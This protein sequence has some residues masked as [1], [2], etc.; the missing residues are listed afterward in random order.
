MSTLRL[1]T[2]SRLKT[3]Q[4]QGN[5]RGSGTATRLTTG[6]RPGTRGGGVGATLNTSVH[7]E[8][9]PITQQGLSGLRTADRGTRRQIEDKPY[10]LGLLRSKIN[11]I[12]S[13]IGVLT[14]QIKETEEENASFIQYEQMAEKLALEIKELQGEL[15]DYNTLVDKATL[16][17]DVSNVEMDWE[18]LKSANE[19]ADKSLESLFEEKQ[20]MDMTLKSLEQELKREQQKSESLVQEMGSEERGNYFRL[21]DLNDHLMAQLTEGQAQLD[22]LNARRIELEQ[23]ISTSQAKQEAMRLYAQ[24]HEAEAK[25]DQL[26]AEEAARDDP[27]RERERLLLQVREDN[28]E[29][30]SI[31]HQT[32]E[33]QEK[34][35]QLEE[36]LQLLEQELDENR[37]ERHQK[38]RELKKREQQIDE[39]LNTF[40]EVKA[41]E[42]SNI[43][44]LQANIVGL[45]ESTSRHLMNIKQTSPSV[46]AAL[47]SAV[48]DTD[49]PVDQL[50]EQ[51]NFKTSEVSKAKDTEAALQKEY[52]RLSQD[53]VKVEQLEAKVTQEMESLRERIARMEAEIQ[54]FDDLDRVKEDAKFKREAV[55][56]EKERME[57]HRESL[58]RMNQQ[59]AKEYANLQATLAND[60]THLQLSNLERRWAQHEQINFSLMESIAN[61]RAETDH[62][63]WAKKAM[64]L[65]RSYNES[66]KTALASKPMVP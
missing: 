47:K 45:L 1:G 10:Y 50:R 28:Q 5:V 26:L 42:Q 43:A 17:E 49:N 56:K 22:Q 65:V 53:I 9:R 15:G 46:V 57:S 2:A 3:A 30:A 29:I 40:D 7:V 58:H 36:E 11:E 39:F 59:L 6:L 52:T 41:L 24:L 23:E 51:L 63:E 62:T 25:R 4:N 55:T 35:A 31:E 14:R 13:E 27:E 38:Y 12:T 19:R 64:E 44:E 34:V 20:Q 8:D 66:L 21:R 33:T 16:G 37:S 60:E 18:A 32:R 54:V 61:K 48:S